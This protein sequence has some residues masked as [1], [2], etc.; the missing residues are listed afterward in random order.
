MRKNDQKG[1]TLPSKDFNVSYSEMP[2]LRV[3]LSPEEAKN[4]KEFIQR[5][6]D[7][8][9]SLAVPTRTPKQGDVAPNVPAIVPTVVAYPDKQR[10]LFRE[11]GNK[12]SRFDPRKYDDNVNRDVEAPKPKKANTAKKRSR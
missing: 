9:I 3:V 11:S 7:S 4:V 10:D 8:E 5:N 2:M 12:K 1:N 6:P